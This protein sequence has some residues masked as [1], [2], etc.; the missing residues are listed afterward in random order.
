MHWSENM[1]FW[2][3][4]GYISHDKNWIAWVYASMPPIC[5]LAC[6]SPVEHSSG[7]YLSFWTHQG[8]SQN[9]WLM[10][11][12]PS[13]QLAFLQ[14]IS[15]LFLYIIY[16]YHHHYP[17]YAYHVFSSSILS[18][19]CFPTPSFPM[20]LPPS[21]SPSLLPRVIPMLWCMYAIQ[22]SGSCPS[23]SSSFIRMFVGH[24]RFISLST[25]LKTKYM[26]VEIDILTFFL[27][28]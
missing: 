18:C 6:H 23:D 27:A 8:D 12:L 19:L 21:S 15:K 28:I 3:V 17:L 1:H 25:I 16:N 20:S 11:N 7:P 24:R 9:L 5:F 2:F 22:D 14:V 26:C 4:C 13:S 10:T